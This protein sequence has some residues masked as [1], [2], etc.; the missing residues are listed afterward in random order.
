[1]SKVFDDFMTTSL[2]VSV[3]VLLT[4]AFI[5]I[6]V[7]RP[8]FAPPDA[9][10]CNWAVVNWAL[11]ECTLLAN[12]SN[13]KNPVGLR[14]SFQQRKSSKMMKCYI[15]SCLYISACDAWKK[16]CIYLIVLDFDERS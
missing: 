2:R 5:G 14:V 7:I 15:L 3:R 11:V 16:Y 9:T 10:V 8:Q 1:L 12:H 4:N 6:S 13:A